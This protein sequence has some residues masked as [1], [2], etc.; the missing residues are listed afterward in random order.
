[1]TD[2]F[3]KTKRSEIMSKI[4]GKDTMPEIIVRKFLHANGL[5]FRK[6]DNRYPGKP[7]ILLPK[8]RTAVFVHGCF[9]H[10]HNCKAGKLPDTRREFWEGKISKTQKRD[11]DNVLKLQALGFKILTIWQCEIDS[12]KSR[13]ITLPL[14]LKNIFK[15]VDGS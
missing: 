14:L 1:M 2:V 4:S 3:S 5:R 12:I 11:L 13:E 7:D 8:Y 15:R 9:W 10:G 6:N